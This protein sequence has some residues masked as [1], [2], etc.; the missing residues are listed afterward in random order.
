MLADLTRQL[1]PL[2]TGT[3]PFATP[4]PGQRARGAH[5]VE[6]RL[7]GEVTFARVDP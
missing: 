4:I 3:S 2:Q 6:P 7:V 1:R 5:W